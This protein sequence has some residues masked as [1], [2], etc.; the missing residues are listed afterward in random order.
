VAHW[1]LLRQKKEKK[2]VVCVHVLCCDSGTR[3]KGSKSTGVKGKDVLRNTHYIRV[4]QQ[5]EPR[6]RG[7]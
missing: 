4:A 2:K 5:V 6:H 7:K 1:G 3:E